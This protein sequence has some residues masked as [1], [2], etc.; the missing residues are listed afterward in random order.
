MVQFTPGADLVEA[1]ERLRAVVHDV[2]EKLRSGILPSAAECEK[3]DCKEEAGRRGRGG[4]LLKGEP[5]N[6]EAARQLANEV[7]CM[8]NTPGGGALLVGV[9]DRTGQLLGAALS[10]D[11]LRQR[12]YQL[13]GVAPAVEEMRVD[14]V[15]LLVL[16]VAEAREPVENLD[17]QIRWRTGG[18]CVAVDRAEWWLHRQLSSGH[19]P[20]A[21]VTERTESDVSPG[22]L[23]V[24]RRYLAAW[25]KESGA[26]EPLAGHNAREL[27]TSLGVLRPDGRLTAAGALAFCAADRN[28]ITLSV[29]DVE[30]GELLAGPRDMAGLSLLEQIALVDERLDALN[31][32]VRVAASGFAQPYVRRLPPGALREAVFNGVVHRDWMQPEPVTVTWIDADSAVR[33]VSPGGFNGG[34]TAETALNQNFAR[35]PALADLFRA[36]HLVEKQGL[37]VDR[38]YREMVA[39]GHRPPLLVEEPGPRVRVRLVGG[40]PVVPVMNLMAAI[41][42]A[43]RQRDVKIALIVHT[44]LHEAFTTPRRLT[45]VLQIGEAEAEE[46]LE[47]AAECVIGDAALITRYKDVWTL[48]R[49]AVSVV[50]RD[51]QEETLRRRGVLR[52]VKP[53]GAGAEEVV[54]RWFADHD[55]YS[56]GDHSALT[57]LTYNGARGQ[58]ERLEQAGV[59]RRGEG[60]GRSAHFVAGPSLR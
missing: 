51:A 53:D 8:A 48:S 40:S 21:Q 23:V 32:Q 15:R 34:V 18:H 13:V 57:G 29:I 28:Y 6:Q 27:L 38:M 11:W 5:H 7:T 10:V 41:R 16:Y 30:G 22:A 44:L 9:E 2:V 43:V 14:G 1:R 58:L 26:A 55:R 50:R 20:M 25:E 36:L 59:L 35:Y 46:A 39:L 60:S 42:P 24:A 56:S 49:D 12:V 17:G 31:T 52:Y 45:K 3:V 54:R 33:V 37:G 47:T 19:D 4:I